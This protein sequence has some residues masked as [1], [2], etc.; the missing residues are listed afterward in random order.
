MLCCVF[1]KANFGLLYLQKGFVHI[2]STR[3]ICEI[4]LVK[5]C[6]LIDADYA[7]EATIAIIWSTH[8]YFGF[9]IQQRTKEGTKDDLDI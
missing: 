2:C 3:V 5:D 8:F 4:N 1:S 9:K 6:R 7:R